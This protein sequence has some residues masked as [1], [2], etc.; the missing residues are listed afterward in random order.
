MHNY[1][2]V[3]RISVANETGRKKTNTQKATLIE[4]F[5]IEGD[6]H[7]GSQRQVSLLQF[8]AFD[9]IRSQFPEISPGDFA[10]NITTRYLDFSSAEIG[11]HL[12]IGA[13]VEVVIT[14][15]GK[16]CHNDCEI[17]RQVGECIMPQLGIFVSVVKG[18]TIQVG[19][20]IIWE[21][22]DD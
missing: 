14:H 18:G 12:Y 3:F 10:E 16:E 7:A 21:T 8:E 19:D 9:D 4:N 13:N 11:D 5:G 22:V 15:I 20:K 6:V 1:G 2:E 17:K